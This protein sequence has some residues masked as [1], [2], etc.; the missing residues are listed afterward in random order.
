MVAQSDNGKG[1]EQGGPTTSG[2]AST[3]ATSLVLTLD[4][5]SC[6]SD[7]AVEATADVNGPG[8]GKGHAYGHSKG[9]GNPHSNSSR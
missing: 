3:S 8:N 6:E 2:Q 1:G 5:A 9:V 4:D 7:V